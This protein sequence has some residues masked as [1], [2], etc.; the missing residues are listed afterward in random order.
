MPTFDHLGILYEA[1]TPNSVGKVE[2]V[3]ELSI[4]LGFKL[5]AIPLGTL[6]DGSPDPAAIEGA[7][8]ALKAKGVQFI[9][10]GSSAFLE[11]NSDQFTRAAVSAGLPVL[12]PYEHMVS[13]SQALMSIAARDYDVGTLAGEQVRRILVEK[14][15]PGELPVLAMENFAYLVNMRVAKALNLYPPVEL[16]QFVEK[17]E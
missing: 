16:L 11:K 3:R 1:Q 4:P 12:T 7:I 14:A 5:E 15:V 9:Y 2:E 10:L 8:A 17:T 6:A 13:S